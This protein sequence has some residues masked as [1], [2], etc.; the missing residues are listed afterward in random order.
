LC[1]ISAFC[2]V[3]DYCECG[4]EVETTYGT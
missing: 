3:Y 1:L 2:V 4:Y